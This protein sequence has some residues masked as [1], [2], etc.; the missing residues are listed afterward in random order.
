MM[1]YL[2]I[3][4]SENI[5]KFYVGYSV[6]L[7]ER[8]KKHNTN[9]KG[10]TGKTNDWKVVYT[11]KF[12]SKKQAFDREREIKKWKSR[13]KILELIYSMSTIQGGA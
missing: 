9:H 13:K 6:N 8:I 12:A 2:Y 4:Y 7:E 3:L 5:D 1:Y 10:F 11:E